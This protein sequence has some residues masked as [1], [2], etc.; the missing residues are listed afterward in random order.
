MP[1][2]PSGMCTHTHVCTH[3]PDLHAHASCMR[4]HTRACVC[5]LGFQKLW[6]TSFLHLKLGLEWIPHRL[7]V[8]PNPYFLTIKSHT[9]YLFNTQRKSLEKTKDLLEKVN[10]RESFFTKHPQ[11]NI[12]LIEAFSILI[13]EFQVY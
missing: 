3:A 8:V 9:W 6:K 5:M 2:K 10:Q 1:Q 4:M 7:G 12:F 11:V 13:F